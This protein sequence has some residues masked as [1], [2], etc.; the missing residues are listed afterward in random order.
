[1]LHRIIV[2]LISYT[3]FINNI[4]LFYE[5]KWRFYQCKWFFNY[6]FLVHVKFNYGTVSNA[7][8]RFKFVIFFVLLFPNYKNTTHYIFLIWLNEC[9]YICTYIHFKKEKLLWS[10][11]IWLGNSCIISDVFFF[12]NLCEYIIKYSYI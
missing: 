7:Y 2:K 5:K 12:K 10:I 3:K 11:L 9:R 6:F 4:N 8:I 1:M